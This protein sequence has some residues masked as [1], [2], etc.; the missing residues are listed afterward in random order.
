VEPLLDRELVAPLTASEQRMLDEHLQHCLEC[1]FERQ[2]RRDFAMALAAPANLDGIDDVIAQT[3][4][5]VPTASPSIR[6]A[7]A[8]RSVPALR[9][10]ARRSLLIGVLML[11]SAAAAAFVAEPLARFWPTTSSAASNTTLT[12]LLDSVRQHIRH[13][14][15]GV[16]RPGTTSLAVAEQLAPSAQ[17]AAQ[18]A[19][20]GEAAT[21]VASES[22][23]PTKPRSAAELFAR[24]NKLRHSG[25]LRDA[26]KWY[27][28]LDTKHPDSAEARL[29]KSIVARLLLDQGQATKALEGYDDVL[30]SNP[31]NVEALMGR[32]GAQRR[33]GQHAAEARTLQRVIATHPNSPHAEAARAR[34]SDLQ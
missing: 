9:N 2:V 16:A 15:L 28:V 25:R 5:E 26:L 31:S 3:L 18:L 8:R 1:R 33:L 29:S 13:T 22:E 12:N 7:P 34:L 4:G 27:G 10:G 14:H 32:A 6:V 11:G 19:L 23:T 21:P 30:R 20:P 17:S 24:A